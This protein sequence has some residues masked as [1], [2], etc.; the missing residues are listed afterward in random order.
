MIDVSNLS[1]RSLRPCRSVAK[2]QV[3]KASP[4]CRFATIL[5]VLGAGGHLFKSDRP[6]PIFAYCTFKDHVKGL[7]VDWP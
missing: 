6:A 3:G 2:K 5:S 4:F 7:I 1:Y